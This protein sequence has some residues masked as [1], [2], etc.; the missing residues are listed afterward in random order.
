MSVDER[1]AVPAD[2]PGAPEPP[3]TS[4]STDAGTQAFDRGDFRALRA[5]LRSGAGLSARQRAA[6]G[7]DP[8]HVAVLV[9]CA[10]GL[11]VIA[12]R[13]FGAEG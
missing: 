13:Y 9:A 6:L 7:V 3:S 2:G 11:A 5:Q 10:L 4:T 1:E 12:A 8:A